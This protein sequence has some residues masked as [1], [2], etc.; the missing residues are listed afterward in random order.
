[1]NITNPKAEGDGSVQRAKKVQIFLIV[2]L[3]LFNMILPTYAQEEPEKIMFT[4]NEIQD[5]VLENSRSLQKIDILTEQVDSLNNIYSNEYDKL[6]YNR[7]GNAQISTAKLND[8]EKGMEQINAAIPMYNL[9]NDADLEDAYQNADTYGIRPLLNQFSL[10]K[11]QYELI[12]QQ[13]SMMY[14]IVE[15]QMSILK[16]LGVADYESLTRQFREKRD[17]TEDTLDDLERTREEAEEQVKQLTT[18][19]VLETIKLENN[20]DLLEKTYNQYLKMTEVERLKVKNGLANSVEA[21]EIAIK[22][23]NYG[24]QY[25]FAQETLQILKG[26]LNDMMG[27]D[28]AEPLKIVEFEVNPT[29]IPAPPYTSIIDQVL[30]NTYQFVKDERA[31]E[32]LEDDIEYV[33]GSNE[34]NIKE[35]EM[36]KISLEM[37]ERKV[38]IKNDLKGLLAEY[39]KKL[40]DFQLAQINFTK[41]SQEYEWKKLE[42]AGGLISKLML[43]GAEL[44]YL[45]AGNEKIAAGY[46]YYLVREELE[47]VKQG[48][49]MPESYEQAKEQFAQ[50]GK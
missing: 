22:A 10:L 32:N 27:R 28:I 26:K 23:S 13:N 16:G 21:Q 3:F 12:Q 25:K 17:E 34:E 45:K 37:E 40:K 42:F 5:R 38:K 15:G 36:E 33:D 31:I 14:E 47:K 6:R 1:M 48:I 18:L 4:L 50:A 8:I 43:T 49:F 9:F 35:K 20:I 2:L 30:E 44:K 19:L 24:K 11:M 29:Y 41:A 7:M 46:D 39:N